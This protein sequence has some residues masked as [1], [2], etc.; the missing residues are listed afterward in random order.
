M[1]VISSTDFR[2]HMSRYI[3]EAQHDKIPVIVTTQKQ[4]A[5]VVV[6]LDEWEALQET[7]Y[8][9]AHP[10]NRARLEQ[11]LQDVQQGQYDFHNLAD[12]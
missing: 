11:A 5:V 3:Q 7:H 9:T 12:L 1:T 6:A 4:G 8:L 10:A 2:K